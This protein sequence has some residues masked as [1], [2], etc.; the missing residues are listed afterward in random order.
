MKPGQQLLEILDNV[1]PA[2]NAISDHDAK[3]F[4]SPE[5]WSKIQ[6]IGHLIDSALNNVGRF[7]R[8]QKTQDLIFDGYDQKYWVEAQHYQ[9]SDWVDTINLFHLINAQIASMVD[10][11]PG[12][13]LSLP[14]EKHSISWPLYFEKSPKNPFT[15]E[16]MIWDYIAHIENHLKQI[17][18][19]YQP[20]VLRA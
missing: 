17:F 1:K 16:F 10:Q 8:L 3:A 11:I 13:I 12:E 14:R 20:K 2:F 15:L 19:D 5:K 7:I 4:P 9:N 6:I 18:T